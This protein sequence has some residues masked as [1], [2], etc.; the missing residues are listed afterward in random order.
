MQRFQPFK[1]WRFVFE[2]LFLLPAKRS[3]KFWRKCIILLFIINLNQCYF[4]R[5]TS[6]GRTPTAGL[7]LPL[8]WES[9][10]LISNSG[11]LLLLLFALHGRR[12]HLSKRCVW[13]SSQ[14]RVTLPSH[15]WVESNLLWWKDKETLIEILPSGHL[16]PS[17]HMDLDKLFSSRLAVRAAFDPPLTTMSKTKERAQLIRC[18][19]VVCHCRSG[20]GWWVS[21]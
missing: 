10:P 1:V 6:D 2:S 16:V 7:S 18:I 21:F 15:A 12:S 9:S 19:A 14:F 20:S 3:T 4:V 17:F 11:L 13:S 5:R 8:L